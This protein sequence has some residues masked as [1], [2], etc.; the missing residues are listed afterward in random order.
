M[1][2]DDPSPL[3][4][5]QM[6]Y[7]NVICCKCIFMLWICI[8][9]YTNLFPQRNNTPTAIILSL[10]Q[11]PLFILK[12]L[13]LQNAMHNYKFATY[14]IK[15]YIIHFIST[16]LYASKTIPVCSRL[17]DHSNTC[18]QCYKDISIQRSH[19]RVW[20]LLTL[21]TITCNSHC[22]MRDK[23]SALS[24]SASLF[25]RHINIKIQLQEKMFK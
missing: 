15:I 23:Q 2:H 17:I 25:M 18:L 3:H 21:R 20:E 10:L 14:C 12:K 19:Q 13:Q 16:S 5:L 24:L 7:H 6:K 8:Y 4:C 9:E 22:N 1:T 11:I